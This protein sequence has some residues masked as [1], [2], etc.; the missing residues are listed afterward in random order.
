MP[1]TIMPGVNVVAPDNFIDNLRLWAASAADTDNA[2]TD[3]SEND[4]RDAAE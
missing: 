3:S 2:S 4:I 1:L